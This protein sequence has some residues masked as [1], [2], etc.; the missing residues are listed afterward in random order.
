MLSVLKEKIL[1]VLRSIAPIIALGGVLQFTIVGAPSALFLQFLGG[2]VLLTLGMA[3]FFVGIDLGILPMG[4]FVGA[5][6]P[7]RSSFALILLVALGLG[8]ATTVAE[9]DVLV[10]AEQVDEVSAGA[11]PGQLVLYVIA[12]GVAVFTALAMARVVLGFSMLVL[13]AAAY[14]AML[15]LAFFVPADFI[16]L[17]F[18]AG[19]VTTGVVAGPV[20]IAVAVGISAVLAGRSPVT[21]GFGLLGIASIGPIIAVCIMGILL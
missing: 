2:S 15:A 16:P 17:A 8:F 11:V 3:I 20:I 10:L 12:G 7:K 9:P 5:A 13:L 18:D 6:L 19:S 14:S 21:D 4:R 1:E